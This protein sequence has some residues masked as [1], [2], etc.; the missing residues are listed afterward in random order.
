MSLILGSIDKIT[1]A[2]ANGRIKS[3]NCEKTLK[4]LGV[5]NND[6]LRLTYKVQGGGGGPSKW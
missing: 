4:E 1:L 3:S 6:T 2:L 5:K